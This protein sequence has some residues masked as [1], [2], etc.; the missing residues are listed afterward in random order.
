MN[1]TFIFVINCKYFAFLA[2]YFAKKNYDPVSMYLCWPFIND[3]SRVLSQLDFCISE[4]LLIQIIRL[5]FNSRAVHK[6][7]NV[8]AVLLF[9]HILLESIMFLPFSPVMMEVSNLC[10]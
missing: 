7:K 3:S 8:K 10:V 2:K 9:S 4:C 6:T 5:L 1:S